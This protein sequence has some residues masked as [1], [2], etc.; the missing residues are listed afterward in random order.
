MSNPHTCTHNSRK[1]G[2][3][4]LYTVIEEQNAHN[5]LHYIRSFSITIFFWLWKLSAD[6][7]M[8]LSL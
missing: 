1:L 5:P 7:T 3:W 8:T 2:L 6:L 4:H